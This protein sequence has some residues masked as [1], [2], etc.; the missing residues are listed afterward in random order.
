VGW[1]K[2]KNAMPAELAAAV[3]SEGQLLA[4]AE[5]SGGLVA[6]T[7][8][9]LVNI[10]DHQVSVTPWTES[11]QAKWEPPQLT[12]IFQGHTD[13]APTVKS[14][15]LAEDSQLPRAV[16]DRV[17]AAVVIDRVFELPTAGRV[18]FVAR[19]DENQAYWSAI[20]DDLGASQSAVGQEE[21]EKALAELRSSF[22]I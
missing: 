19:K 13:V 14:W 3:A 22:G 1:F 11:L 17:T 15:K 18:R 2:Q 7:K 16:R 8:N 6:V 10:S 20:A 21:I 4:W 9:S 12:V 5:H